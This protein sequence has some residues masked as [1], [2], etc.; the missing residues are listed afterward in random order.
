MPQTRD[1]DVDQISVFI[2][3]ERVADLDSVGWDDSADHEH[4]RTMGDDGNIWVIVD[5][6]VERLQNQYKRKR[7]DQVISAMYEGA[8]RIKARE[9]EETF[10]KL[11][12][13]EESEAVVESMADTLVSQLLASPT[14]SLRDAAENDDWSTIH[15]A[16]RL[17]NPHIE[18]EVTEEGLF[19]GMVGK[20]SEGE[21]APAVDGSE[22]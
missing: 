2:D 5:E 1:F 18:E 3:G 6:E 20:G 13:D 21:S 11:D 22:E 15:T 10:E 16:L 17:F 19:E 4:N 7:A 9:L 8:E 12:L 14:N